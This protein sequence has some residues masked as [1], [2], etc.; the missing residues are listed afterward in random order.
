MFGSFLPS[1]LVGLAPPTLLGNRSRHCHGISYTVISVLTLALGI[2]TNMA[3]FS[4]VYATLWRPLPYPDSSDLAAIGERN[5]QAGDTFGAVAPGNFY[6]WRAQNR[7]FSGMTAFAKWPFNLTGTAEPQRITG[8][9]VTPEFFS[10][11]KVQPNV[12]RGFLSDEDERNKSNVTVVSERLWERLFGPG[13]SLHGQ[14][15]TLNGT[16]MAVVGVMPASFAYPDKE[17]ELWV[18]L[19]LDARNRQDREGKW[20][21]V[22]GRMRPGIRLQEGRKDLQAIAQRL[23]G[24]YPSTNSGWTADLRPLH[25]AIFGKLQTGS[26]LLLSAVGLILLVACFNVAGLIL[27]RSLQRQGELATRMALGATQV[28]IIRGLLAEN[29]LIGVL[30]VIAG[31]ILG[32]WMTKT[33]GLVISRMI[34]ALDQIHANP[35]ALVVAATVAVLTLAAAS[36]LPG[37]QL[38]RTDPQHGLR[39][40]GRR[41]AGATTP[42]RK[43]VVV[44]QVAF[45]VILI[46]GTTLLVK[47]FLK[48]RAV[49]PGFDPRNTI[50]L[51]LTLPRSKYPTNPQQIAFLQRVLDDIRA[52]PGVEHAAAISDLPLR[53]NSM[54]FK[55]MR[56]GDEQ[57]PHDKLPQAGVRWVTPDYFDTMR[58]PLLR[59][60]FPDTQDVA[61]GP[62]IAVVNRSMERRFWPTG[63]ALGANIRLEEDPRWFRVVGIVDDVKQL[64]LAADEVPAVYLPHAQKAQ[65][66]MNWMSLVV[67]TSSSAGTSVADIRKTIYLLDK[68]QPIGTVATLQDYF[69]AEVM[70]PRFSSAVFG[71][72]STIALMVALVGLYGVLAYS[73]RQRTHEIGIRMALGAGAR[74]VVQ[75]VFKEGA[76]LVALG[77]FIGLLGTLW[78]TRLMAKIV[79]GFRATDPSI[80]VEVLVAIAA[81][82]LVAC[83]I[84][85]LRVARIDP[86]DALRYE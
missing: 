59:G 65:T 83:Y 26:F 24:G 73:I 8:A 61:G 30:G 11:L 44:S 67:R 18:P 36:A 45:A 76:K 33:I 68:D 86:M 62:L 31:M 12:G 70:L 41:H 25:E 43:F 23:E 72:F 21:S 57:L 71:G 29:G 9:M 20:L 13:A 6:D 34:P 2:A 35:A 54:T 55:I 19:S 7:V 38:T 17:V 77:L 51:E 60:R 46:T 64:S 75:L 80:L 52:T 15:I 10:V 3:G 53:N 82:T 78:L 48:L 56:E 1:L 50:T 69:D 63:N 4:I 42:L 27:A 22:L 16:A 39:F 81:L 74:D 66:W 84:P 37:L 49:D 5:L 32:V 14:A 28:R 58:I 85:A 79:Y 40:A 47:T